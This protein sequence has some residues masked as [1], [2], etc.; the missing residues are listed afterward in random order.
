MSRA[1]ISQNRSRRA[2]TLVLSAMLLVLVVGIVAFAIDVGYIVLVRTQLQAAADSAALA[3]ASRMSAEPAEAVALAQEFAAR[4]VAGGQPIELGSEQVEFGIWDSSTRSFVA[5]PSGAGNAVRVTARRQR[6]PLFFGRI[7][8]RGDFDTSAS[9]VAMA[10]PR[11]IAFVVDLSGSMNDDTEPHWATGAINSQ[12]A[13]EGYPTIGSQLMQQV[14]EDFG[15]GIYPGVLEYIGLPL[16]VK[17]DSYAYAEMTKD[18]GPLSLPAIPARYRIGPGDNEQVRKQ[19]AYSWMIDFQIAR[20]MPAAVPKPNSANGDS[21]AYWEKYLDYIIERKTIRPPSSNNNSNNNNSNN[22]SSNNNNKN[23]SSNNNSGGSSSGGGGGSSSPPKPPAGHYRPRLPRDPLRPF[24]EEPLLAGTQ[25]AAAADSAAHA[26]AS[27]AGQFVSAD[28]ALGSVWLAIAGLRAAPSGTLVAY[29]APKNN[30]AN[31]GNSKNNTNSGNSSGSANSSKNSKN[32]NNSSSSNNSNSSSNSNAGA[33]G[34]TGPATPGTPPSNRGTI[35]PN[36]GE[37]I[38]GFNNPNKSTFPSVSSSVP[39]S[40][41]NKIGYLTYVAFMMDHGRD[42]PVVGQQYTPLSIHHPQCPYHA[43]D[44]DGGT[45]LF[46]PREQPTHAARRAIIA[47]LQVV[48]EQNANIADPSQRDWVSI[49]TFD[50]LTG[51]GPT[52]VQPLTA[53]YDAAMQAC[54]RLQACSDKN[55]FST[56][57]EAG[58]VVARQHLQ[59]KSQGGAGREATNRVVVLLT[60]GVP[61]LYVSDD[62][63]IDR[64]VLDNPNSDW[65]GNG[66][67]WLDAPLMQAAQMQLGG[68]G[69]FPVGVGL[70]TDYGFMDRMAR[71]GGTADDNGQSPRGSGNPAQYEQRLKEIFQNIITSPKV[72]LVQ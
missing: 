6:A 8:G 31:N 46:P 35:P 34:A 19:K 62:A 40:F 18:F 24:K 14:Y 2:A 45:F 43:E 38:D 60:D 33:A 57:T 17:S 32:S 44:T 39:K 25:P 59:P 12:F 15:F 13:S 55:S 3:A 63:T 70:G 4:H 56:A 71:M 67:Y 52:I 26:G 66:Q 27:S 65:Y 23:N 1:R 48:K 28:V 30:A 10:N 22:N 69:V 11:E 16:G 58:L 21:Y 53:D 50:R 68:W 7:F 54:T 47:A 41:R 29:L 36:V 42:S 49:I 72:R 20:V 64:F 61:N 51:G 37:Q 5:L 9:A